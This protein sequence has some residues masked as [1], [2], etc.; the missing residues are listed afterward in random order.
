MYCKAVA[1]Q[2]EL[3]SLLVQHWHIKLLLQRGE[4]NHADAGEEQRKG[5]GSKT[6]ENNGGETSN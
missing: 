5:K 6:A 4:D 1:L 2:E 3:L